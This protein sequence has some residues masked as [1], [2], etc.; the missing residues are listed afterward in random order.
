MAKFLLLFLV[1]L[2]L[3]ACISIGC[4]SNT[5]SD[6]DIEQAILS[7]LT[8]SATTLTDNP[9]RNVEAVEVI[10]VGEPYEQGRMTMWPVTVKIMRPNQEE[11]AEYI[12]F[13]DILG[14]IKILR[15]SATSSFQMLLSAFQF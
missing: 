8:S 14:H 12:I 15:R 2:L 1:L 7:Y 5:P 4:T 9:N 3:L 13:K 10:E 11:Q 6:E